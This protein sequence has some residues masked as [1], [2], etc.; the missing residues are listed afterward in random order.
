MQTRIIRTLYD[1]L[2]YDSSKIELLDIDKEF[3]ESL[4]LV[5]LINSRNEQERELMIN[6]ALLLI[7]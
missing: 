1:V 3:C 7:H 6:F 2:V 5:K 4:D